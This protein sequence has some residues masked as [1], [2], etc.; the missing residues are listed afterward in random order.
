[1]LEWKYLPSSYITKVPNQSFSTIKCVNYC[2]Y[3][4]LSFI[5]HGLFSI[6]NDINCELFWKVIYTK[7]GLH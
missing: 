4:Y 7:V 5:K 6:D 2:E 3:S 1:M